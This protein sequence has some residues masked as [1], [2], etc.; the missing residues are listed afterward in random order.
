MEKFDAICPCPDYRVVLSTRSSQLQS[1]H[2]SKRSIEHLEQCTCSRDALQALAIRARK[3]AKAR[4][5]LR[6]ACRLPTVASPSHN[7]LSRGRISD[8]RRARTSIHFLR[9]SVPGLMTYPTTHGWVLGSRRGGCA[10]EPAD[11]PDKGVHGPSHLPIHT[12]SPP[13]RN[14]SVRNVTRAREIWRD[15][16]IF[17]VQECYFRSG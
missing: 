15:G 1:H 11:P 13:F 17:D 5:G 2:G 8:W 10:V 16:P 3:Q 12:S 7:S 4:H 9:L 6:A 14:T